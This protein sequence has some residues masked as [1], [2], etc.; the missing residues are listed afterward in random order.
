MNAAIIAFIQGN[1]IGILLGVFILVIALTIWGTTITVLQR[2]AQKIL[3][4]FMKEIRDD[5]KDIFKRLPAVV[6][7]AQSPVQLTELGHE[8]EKEINASTWVVNHIDY[9]LESIESHTPYHIQERCFEYAQNEF[10]ANIV[11]DSDTLKDA[12]ERTA[13]NHG[14]SLS[15]VLEVVGIVLRD[16]VLKRLDMT[17][18][19]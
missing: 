4:G 2:S 19:A 15:Q 9:I 11:P 12:I 14:L 6:A 18:P 7:T 5:I 3:T 17:P 13:F 16:E 10:M 1:A 8:I